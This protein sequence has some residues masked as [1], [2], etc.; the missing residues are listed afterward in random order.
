[1]KQQP[2]RCVSACKTAVSQSR[3]RDPRKI[4]IQSGKGM[5]DR[6]CHQDSGTSGFITIELPLRSS[7]ALPRCRRTHEMT[8]APAVSASHFNA[9]SHTTR[10]RHPASDRSPIALASLRWLACSFD[11]QNSGLVAGNR[12]NGQPSWRCQKHPCTKTA[13]FQRRST[14]SGRP[15]K[16]LACKRKRSPADQSARRTSSSGAVSLLRMRDIAAER[17][18]LLRVSAI[19]KVLIHATRQ[20]GWVRRGNPSGIRVTDPAHPIRRH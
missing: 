15:G 5:D 12:N 4:S 2:K 1:M 14:I 7:S 8:C 18:S 11:S 19:G 16:V 9:H 10:T 3:Q 13:A 17:C 6:R 20:H